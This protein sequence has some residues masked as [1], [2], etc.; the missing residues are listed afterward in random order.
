MAR[1]TIAD[2]RFA[3]RL[4]ELL[5][6]RGTSYRALA[7][8]TFYSKSYLHDL[9]SGRKSPTVE[10]A[11]RL[12]QA[13]HA[14]GQLAALA[15][16]APA[17]A[18][19]DEVQ[20]LELARRVEASDVSGQTLD[21][22]E[23]AVD[24]LAMAYAGT[25]PAPLLGRVRH[26]LAMVTR[27]LD[28]RA[29]LAQ[30]RRLM[31]A[32]GW[33]SLLAATTHID[34]RQSGAAYARL[35]TASC[36]AGHADHQ[37]I[38]AWCL[39]TRAWDVLTAG[40]YRQAVELSRQAQTMAPEGS[41]AQIQATAQEGR[42]WARMRQQPETRAALD[43]VNR[44]TA[45]L[46]TPDRPEHHYRYD[47]DKALSYTATT[48]AWAGDPAAE[49]YTRALIGQLEQPT[50]GTPRPRRVASARLD[51][52]LALLAAGK[53]DEAAAEATAAIATGRIVPSNWWR[54]TEV[55]AAV[56]PLGVRE[57]ADLRE[58]YETHQPAGAA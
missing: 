49:Q 18:S 43:R 15:E 27:L 11:Q 54:A 23:A 51:L 19:G 40:D 42:A 58:V 41:S 52:S 20:A 29:T 46:T 50:N 56:E 17:E 12:D 7:A 53:P 32:A 37:E 57:A 10:T 36:L 25:P 47:P 5:D 9:A 26:H 24:E 16:P 3:A 6:E 28:G 4:R 35:S 39:E 55:L 33:L 34:L 38:G 14:D 45:G 8:A 21:G 2:P 1:R 22:L 44:L 13:L 48:L 30:Q 31:V